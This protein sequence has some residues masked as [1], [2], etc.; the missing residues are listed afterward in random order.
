MTTE[1]HPYQ[2]LFDFEQAL[3]EFTGAPFVVATDC[4]THALKVVMEKEDPDALYK[5]PHRT[6]ISVPMMMTNLG[7]YIEFDD[8]PW[9]GEYQ[10]GP[11]NVW[12]SALTCEPGMYKGDGAIQCLSFGPGK[13]LELFHGGAILLDDGDL[14]HQLAMRCRD[15]RDVRTVPWENQRRWALGYHYPMR[16]ETAEAGLEKLETFTGATLT[17]RYPDL[18][19]VYEG[20]YDTLL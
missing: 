8:T 20:N 17:K 5:I 6:Y 19:E 14:A 10:I 2:S 11:S 13:P 15:G 3:A 4:C 18:R 1:K 12:D 7:N 9:H 16:L